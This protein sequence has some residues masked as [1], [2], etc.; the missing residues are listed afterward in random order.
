MK[1]GKKYQYMYFL[2]RNFDSSVFLNFK[3]KFTKRF[4]SQSFHLSN[5]YFTRSQT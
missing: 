5:K 1:N 3:I 2:K 4:A